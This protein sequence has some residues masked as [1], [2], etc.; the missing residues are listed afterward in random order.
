MLKAVIF[1]CDGVIAE[2]EIGRFRQLK[3]LAEEKG[4]VGLNENEHLGHLVGKKSAD[5]LKLVFG[6][7]ISEREIEEI[8]SRRYKDWEET[9]E[10]FIT[11]MKGIR[12]VCTELEKKYELAV[13]STAP[14]QIVEATLNH[15]GLRKHFKVIMTGNDVKRGKPDPEVYIQTLKKLNREGNECLAIEDSEAGMAAAKQAG[16]KVV[17]LRNKLY[18]QY[19]HMEDMSKADIVIEE[20]TDLLKIA[21]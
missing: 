4:H 7:K 11:P 6:E 5:L 21:Q 8:T 10:K 17:G 12:E 9:P 2:T 20:L 1:D 15:L 3:K 13:A 16:I 19:G 14:R 18:E